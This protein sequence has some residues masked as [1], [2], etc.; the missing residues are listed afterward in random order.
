[1]VG[2]TAAKTS[3]VCTRRISF[4]GALRTVRAHGEYNY[5]RYRAKWTYWVVRQRQRQMPLC[6]ADAAVQ[7]EQQLNLARSR[8]TDRENG[9]ENRLPVFTYERSPTYGALEAN[10]YNAPIQLQ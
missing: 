7:A 3:A 1:M 2:S 9:Y 8:E 5:R 4:L 10:S 6:R